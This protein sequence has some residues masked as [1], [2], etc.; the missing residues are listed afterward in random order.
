MKTYKKLLSKL[1]IEHW[2]MIAV[3]LAIYDI[4][5]VNASYLF[6]LLIR[7][8]FKF[9]TIPMDYYYAFL[10]FAPI[11]TVFSLGVFYFFKMYSFILVPSVLFSTL[12]ISRIVAA[13]SA[14]LSLVPRFTSSR[15]LLP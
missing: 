14:K 8:D 3:Y 4:I 15:M 11:Y 12:K 10:K 1:N 2:K 7:F 9:S 6:G 5:A 13:I